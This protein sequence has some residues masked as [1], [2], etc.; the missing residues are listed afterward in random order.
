MFVLYSFFDTSFDLF[1]KFMSGMSHLIEK[2]YI[3]NMKKVCCFI[4][5]SQKVIPFYTKKLGQIYFFNFFW[6]KRSDI[7]NRELFLFCVIFFKIHGIL[8]Q[9]RRETSGT[10]LLSKKVKLTIHFRHRFYLFPVF[11]FVF[12]HRNQTNFWGISP[13]EQCKT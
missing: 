1:F 2:N 11:V 9:K 3:F 8:L 10:N 12:Q 5:T 6:N 7:L 13:Y 4:S